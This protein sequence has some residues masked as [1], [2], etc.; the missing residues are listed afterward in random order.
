MTVYQGV[1]LTEKMT[2]LVMTITVMIV[3]MQITD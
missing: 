2:M 3:R 1:A